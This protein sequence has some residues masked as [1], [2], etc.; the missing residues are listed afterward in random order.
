[1]EQQPIGNE[2]P[3]C[4]SPMTVATM[5]CHGCSVRVEAAFPTP[6]L[7]NLPIEQQRFIE[8][9]VLASGSLKEIAQQAG[10][11][12]PTVRSRFDAVIAALGFGDSSGAEDREDI[13]ARLERDEITAEEAEKLLRGEE[14]DEK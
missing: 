14:S 6:R 7:G 8:M 10:V 13:L 1:M 2:C 11:S 9:F 12:Y 5:A 4:G 3:Y